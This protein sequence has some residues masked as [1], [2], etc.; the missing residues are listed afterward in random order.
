MVMCWHGES[1]MAQ[2]EVFPHVDNAPN[3]G[4]GCIV[5]LPASLQP[6]G[7]MNADQMLFAVRTVD[8]LAAVDEFQEVD[9][10]I[11]PSCETGMILLVP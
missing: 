3:T 10:G 1:D 8:G 7:M 4:G 6:E 9:N 11:S 5:A 2:L